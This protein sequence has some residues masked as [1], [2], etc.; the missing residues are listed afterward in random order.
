MNTLWFVPL[1]AFWCHDGNPFH[2]RFNRALYPNFSVQPSLG[3]R[4]LFRGLIPKRRKPVQAPSRGHIAFRRMQRWRKAWSTLSERQ[5][6]KRTIKDGSVGSRCDV[7]DWIQYIGDQR[8]VLEEM[9]FPRFR[10]APPHTN[11]LLLKS[12]LKSTY[13]FLFFLQT[14]AKISNVQHHIVQNCPCLQRTLSHTRVPQCRV[15]SSG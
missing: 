6:L 14:R 11:S 2:R 9:H 3:T 7:D 10:D 5:V 13:F 12:F 8:D 4:S 1:D 15:A